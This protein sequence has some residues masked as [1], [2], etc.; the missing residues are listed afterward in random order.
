MRLSYIDI[1]TSRLVGGCTL[2]MV[3]MAESA[4]VRPVVT[5]WSLRPETV[6]VINVRGLS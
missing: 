4:E 1:P 2:R 3:R 5:A 6:D